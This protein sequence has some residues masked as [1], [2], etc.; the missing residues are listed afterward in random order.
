MLPPLSE[1][2][3]SAEI[4]FKVY[5]GSQTHK[6]ML[7]QWHL[8]VRNATHNHDPSQDILGY[9][10]VYRLTKQYIVNVEVMT[11]ASSHSKEIMTTLRQN[12]LL[13]LITNSDIYNMHAKLQQQNLAGKDI[14]NYRWALTHVLCLFDRAEIPGIIVTNRELALMNA[15]NI[16]FPKW[17]E[18]QQ[19]IAQETLKNIIDTSLI[20]QNLYVVYMKEYLLGIS[21]KQTNST[22]RDPSSFELIDHK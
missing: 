22:R 14:E 20:L 11:I 16:I 1:V 2:Y 9:P 19:S 7:C 13:I 4:L 5:K 8:E 21:N 17:L 6:D 18:S 12:N 10:I 15:L 3:N